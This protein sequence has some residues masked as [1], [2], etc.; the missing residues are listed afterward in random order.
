MNIKYIVFRVAS[1]LA[2]TISIATVPW[3]GVIK[4]V[5]ASPADCEGG[6]N[7]FRNIPDNLIG[8]LVGAEWEI[9]LGV[10]NDLW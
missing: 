10:I 4:P 9:H 8:Q 5:T 1:I 3:L 6:A 2:L 7:G